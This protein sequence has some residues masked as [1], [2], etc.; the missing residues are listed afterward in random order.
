MTSGLRCAT[1]SVIAGDRTSRRWNENLRLPSDRGVGEVRERAGRQVVDDVDVPALGEQP[2]GERGADEPGSAGHER[3]H[4]ALL[5]RRAAQPRG[6]PPRPSRAAPGGDRRT[7]DSTTERS[8]RSVPRPRP[9]RVRA[10]R[11]RP[12]RPAS[13]RAPA[14]M[15]DGPTTVGGRR[16]SRRRA[17]TQTPVARARS[18]PATGGVPSRPRGHVEL[19]LEVLLRRADVEPVG[20]ATA[21]RRGGPGSSSMRGNVSRSIDTVSRGGIASSTSGSST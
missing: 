4:V 17:A 2:V 19:R 20:V 8:N 11:P 1:R 13:T 10:P 16:R 18:R 7:P 5:R 3:L 9:S 15:T 6:R 21:S 12:A 14:P